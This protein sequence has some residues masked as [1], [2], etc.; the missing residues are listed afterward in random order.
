MDWLLQ[1]TETTGPTSTPEES[2][3]ARDLRQQMQT[4]AAKELLE[5]CAK[6]RDH[7]KVLWEAQINYALAQRLDPK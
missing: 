7:L 2:D 4:P 5:Q 6:P 3:A 1:K